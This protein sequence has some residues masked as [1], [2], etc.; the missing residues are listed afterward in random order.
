VRVWK[1]N[2]QAAVVTLAEALDTLGG[3]VGDLLVREERYGKIVREM[4][5][6]EQTHLGMIVALNQRDEV[7]GKLLSLLSRGVGVVAVKIGDLELAEEVI[8]TVDMAG[9]VMDADTKRFMEEHMKE[10]E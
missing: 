5:A 3:V 4:L 2:L 7:F 10:E 9:V 6:R 1:E 8:R